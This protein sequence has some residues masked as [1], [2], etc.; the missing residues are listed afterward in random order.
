[1][2]ASFCDKGLEYR[3]INQNQ[4]MGEGRAKRRPE[5]QNQRGGGPWCG[6]DYK[7]HLSHL[8]ATFLL[9]LHCFSWK[10]K[11]KYMETTWSA[12]LS[13]SSSKAPRHPSCSA[14]VSVVSKITYLHPGSGAGVCV[15]QA[16]HLRSHVFE[17][18][19]FSSYTKSNM[20]RRYVAA[21]CRALFK[22][23]RSRL[24]DCRSWRDSEHPTI[25][26]V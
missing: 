18:S 8:M 25:E 13:P 21:L 10:P 5:I 1:V 19:L 24:H 17:S 6:V 22:I 2:S 11:S 23:R 3:K 12:S 16:A 20:Q 4:T 7:T 26:T 15:L 9:Y 14:L